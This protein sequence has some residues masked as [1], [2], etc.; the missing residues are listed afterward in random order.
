MG[1]DA[2][3][4]GQGAAGVKRP[5]ASSTAAIMASPNTTSIAVSSTIVAPIVTMLELA[6]SRRTIPTLSASPTRAGSTALAPI[7][8]T[9]AP[10]VVRNRTGDGP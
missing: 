3:R 7:E 2:R 1:E 5:A 6:T 10:S 8:L 9:N 4:G